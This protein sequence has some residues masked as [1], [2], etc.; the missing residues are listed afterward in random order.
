MTAQRDPRTE[1][2]RGRGAS[3][4]LTHLAR[5]TGTGARWVREER[6]AGQVS[7]RRPSEMSVIGVT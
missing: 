5:G 3:P 2:E 4:A 7:V 6:V 1:A